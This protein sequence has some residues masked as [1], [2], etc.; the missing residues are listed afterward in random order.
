MRKRFGDPLFVRV[1]NRMAPTPLAMELQE[2]AARVLRI[3]ETEIAE[4]RRFDPLA[5]QRDFRV[6]VNEIGAMTLI[7][8]LVKRL[9]VTAPGAR[10][11]P[12]NPAPLGTAGGIGVGRRGHRGRAFPRNGRYAV[13]AA[14]FPPTLR[15]RRAR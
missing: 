8:R 9:S 12:V 3:L 13:A 6:A 7:P 1:G 2:P 15:L 10:L 5:M 14:A 11:S 4:I